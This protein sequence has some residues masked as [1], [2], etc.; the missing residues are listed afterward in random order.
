MIT[1][2][3]GDIKRL[4][5]SPTSPQYI[6]LLGDIKSWRGGGNS[7]IKVTGVIVGNFERAEPDEVPESCL[8]GVA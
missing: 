3:G 8:M 2:L 7:H 6:K 4:A 1:L 5:L